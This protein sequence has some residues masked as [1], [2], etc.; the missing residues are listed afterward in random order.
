MENPVE[1]T[2]RVSSEVLATLDYFASRQHWSR[3][4]AVDRLLV[5]GLSFYNLDDPGDSSPV[6]SPSILAP[7]ATSQPD[8]SSFRCFECGG[9]RLQRCGADWRCLDCHGDGSADV[10]N[11][12]SNL[13]PREPYIQ[14]EDLEPTFVPQV[15]F[16]EKPVGP[17][18][19]CGGTRFGRHGLDVICLDCR[20][21]EGQEYRGSPPT[22]AL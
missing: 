15:G 20:E 14:R 17:C 6:E 4:K 7:H 22:S 3:D 1:I 16:S 13:E 11:Q 10:E 12:V 19:H 8:D 18:G 5:L 9:S 2:V 21:N